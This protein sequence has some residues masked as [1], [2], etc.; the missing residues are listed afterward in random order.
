M[1]F[2]P[3]AGMTAVVKL[4]IGTG[5]SDVLIPAINWTLNED[6][7]LFDVSN[8]RDGRARFPTLEDCSVGLTLVW[9]NA[10][11]PTKTTA[12]NVRKGLAGQVKLITGPGVNDFYLLP[13][14]VNT[15]KTANEGVENVLMQDV[16]LLQSGGA[17]QLPPDS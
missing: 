6:P 4:S 10:D 14:R 16:E 12:A 9:D 8:F 17:L 2:T 13:I 11:R 1:P 15:V 3:I 5:G 7:K